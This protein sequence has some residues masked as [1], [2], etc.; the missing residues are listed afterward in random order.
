MKNTKDLDE[1]RKL[2]K[3]VTALISTMHRHVD[4][5]EEC[6]RLGLPTPPDE[7]SKPERVKASL[8]HLPD[9][10]LPMVADK[11]LASQLPV[12][13]VIRNKIQDVLWASYGAREIPKRTR[14]EIA[15]ALDLAELVHNADRFMAVLHSLWVLGD[16]SLGFL[17]GVR[18]GLH[19]SIEQH[20]LRN[21]AQC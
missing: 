21:P 13:A 6:E 5:G 1:L 18:T 4:L 19:A 16:D 15:R 7:G 17:T 20:V 14:H 3:N 2:L 12:D 11:V 10:D 9:A 8:A